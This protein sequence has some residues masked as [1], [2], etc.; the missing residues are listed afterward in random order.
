MTVP[1][2]GQ[3]VD[4]ASVADTA[5]A[6]DKAKT[7]ARVVAFL[8]GV[9]A[10]LLLIPVT[11]YF[12]FIHHTA[13]MRSTMT[14]G[15]TSL[16]SPIPT[17]SPIPY[18]GHTTIRMLWA[19]HNES[20]TFFPNLIVLALGAV[21]N[22]NTLTELYL[23]AVLLLIALV[24]VILAHRQDVAPIRLVF[25]LPVTF[26]MF[27]LGQFENTLLGYQLWLVSGHYIPVA[28]T[29]FLLNL[30]RV[31]LDHSRHGYRNGRNRELLGARGTRHLA[32]RPGRLTLQA[33][34]SG[35]LLTWLIS[36]VA[37]TGL[38]FYHFRLR[39]SSWRGPRYVLAH[40]LSA[41]GILLIR[42][43]RLMG[44]TTSTG[45]RCFRS[46]HCHTRGWRLS[47]GCS[48]PRLYTGEAEVFRE[49]R[50]GQH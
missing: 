2:S 31:E 4:A 39:R 28:A 37:T 15:M 21:T 38:Y 32:S 48:V 18:A 35:V 33:P 19:Q 23:S 46:A 1:T 40:P 8:A 27:T 47:S 14:S 11:L 5:D 36:A 29:I 42:D 50:S 24:L 10:V 49:V 12:M 44:K 6:P 13:S 3:T 43:W 41:V 22:L 20:R 16:C 26:L 34:S 25:Y 45:I 30:R 7:R 9:A 17:T